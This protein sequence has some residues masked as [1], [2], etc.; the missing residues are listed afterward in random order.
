MAKAKSEETKAANATKKTSKRKKSASVAVETADV[1]Q[2]LLDQEQ[3]E[4]R[5]STEEPAAVSTSGAETAGDESERESRSDV[6]E[7]VRDASVDEDQPDVAENER[8]VRYDIMITSERAGYRPPKAAIAAVVQQLAF[9]GFA[10]PVDEAIAETWTEIYFEP[11][12]AAHEIFLEKEYDD[13][14]PVYREIMMRFCDK[15]FT[16][17]YS[18]TPQRPLYWG[19]EIRGA[20]FTNP[21]GSFRKLFLDAINLRIAVAVRPAQP[22]PPHL[23]VPDDEKPVDKKK[24]ERG[25]GLA[26]TEV[27][28]V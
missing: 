22:L 25:R 28:E 24:R 8:V 9:R 15:P 13:S 16:C 2:K 19:I 26:G 7:I 1:E 6:A 12:P 20:R 17:D 10:S 4:E 27:E 3:L 21:L 14:I 11:G 18:D 23:V 5:V